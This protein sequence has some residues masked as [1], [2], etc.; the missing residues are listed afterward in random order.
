MG[1]REHTTFLEMPVDMTYESDSEDDQPKT[2]SGL[3]RSPS[4]DD[5]EAFPETL[6]GASPVR[7]SAV[8][9]FAGLAAS[10][11]GHVSTVQTQTVRKPIRRLPRVHKIYQDRSLASKPLSN[12]WT[13]YADEGLQDQNAECESTNCGTINT[14]KEFFPVWTG[15]NCSHTVATGSNIRLFK[16]DQHTSPSVLDT[17]LEQGGKWSI[18]VSKTISRDM[19]EELALY[20]LDERL[21]EAVVGTVFAIRDEVDLQQTSHHQSA[22]KKASKVNKYFLVEL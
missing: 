11:Q 14:M 3:P 16:T 10:F 22:F 6:G 12:N 20:L 8:P 17:A 5:S 13:L 21:G 18:P 15:F 1:A 7:A 19:F 4:F 9:N 2:Q